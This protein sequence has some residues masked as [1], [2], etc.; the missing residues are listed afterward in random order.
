MH[1]VYDLWVFGA[2]VA[3]ARGHAW[4][5]VM[6]GGLPVL[7]Y[8]VPTTIVLGGALW[9]RRLAALAVALDDVAEAEGRLHSQASMAVVLPDEPAYTAEASIAAGQIMRSMQDVSAESGEFPSLDE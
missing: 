5:G 1:G 8:V 9:L 2:P 6:L 4:M 3:I 7:V